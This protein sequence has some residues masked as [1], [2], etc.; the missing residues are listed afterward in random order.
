MFNA[1]WVSIDSFIDRIMY[2]N[3][4]FERDNQGDALLDKSEDQGG[5]P[6]KLFSHLVAIY[7]VCYEMGASADFFNTYQYLHIW[8]VVGNAWSYLY[9][10]DFFVKYTSLKFISL[11]IFIFL[12]INKVTQ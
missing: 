8:T 4:D 9:R 11:K 10:T 7:I 3:H 5:H 1:Y 12:L 2:D 6:A